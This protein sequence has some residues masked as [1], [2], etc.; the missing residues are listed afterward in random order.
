MMEGVGNIGGLIAAIYLSEA[1]FKPDIYNLSLSLTCDPDMCEVC[2]TPRGVITS[3]QLKLLFELIDKRDKGNSN[4]PLLVAAAGNNTKRLSMPASFSNVL[5]VGSYDMN[6]ENI[7]EYSNYSSVPNNRY[8][9]A[10]GGLRDI[11]NCIAQKPKTEWDRQGTFYG[12]SFSAA[13]V[14]GIAARYYCSTKDSPCHV[15]GAKP[16]RDFILRCFDKSSIKTIS[17][18]NPQKHGMGLIKYDWSVV[19]ECI[20]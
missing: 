13:F 14:T 9:L 11:Q 18:F 12:T 1:Q 2:G 15:N 16:D 8:V 3:A 10:P 6:S 19:H 20:T 17:D 5:A 7:A 4:K